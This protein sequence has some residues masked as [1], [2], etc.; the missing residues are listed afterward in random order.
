[1]SSR[2]NSPASS[3]ANIAH[4]TLISSTNVSTISVQSNGTHPHEKDF[5]GGEFQ[6][7]NLALYPTPEKYN[8]FKEHHEK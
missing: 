3:A 4:D 1:M 5:H 2:Q 7:T 6:N 8:H